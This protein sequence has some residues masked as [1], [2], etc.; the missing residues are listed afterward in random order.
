VDGARGY[1]IGGAEQLAARLGHRLLRLETGTEQPEAVILHE[2][3]GWTRIPCYGYFKDHPTTICFE[4]EL[5]GP[6]G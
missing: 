1:G 2:S 4:K 6:P 5:P 3:A